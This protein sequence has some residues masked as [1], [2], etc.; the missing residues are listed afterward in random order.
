MPEK[1]NDVSSKLLSK[2]IDKESDSPQQKK[3]NQMNQYG[4]PNKP[5]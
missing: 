5:K 2:K 1:N 4:K 3:G